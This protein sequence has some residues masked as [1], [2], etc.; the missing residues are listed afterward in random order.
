MTRGFIWNNFDMMT[1]MLH[2]IK[3]LD[4]KTPV[5]AVMTILVV[6]NTANSMI[7]MFAYVLL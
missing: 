5:T 6:M 7:N 3:I 1:T 4:A 2:V